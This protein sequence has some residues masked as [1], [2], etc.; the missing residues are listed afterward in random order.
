MAHSLHNLVLDVCCNNTHLYTSR[1]E[2]L[3][4]EYIQAK[5]KLYLQTRK[6]NYT[7]LWDFVLFFD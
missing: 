4:V 3:Q 1:E 5:S 2:A 6:L 7:L